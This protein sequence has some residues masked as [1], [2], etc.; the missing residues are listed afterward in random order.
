MTLAGVTPCGLGGD[1][2]DLVLPPLLT[3]WDKSLPSSLSHSYSFFLFYYF[4]NKII[5]AEG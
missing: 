2:D 4:R 1:R 5:K 3:R